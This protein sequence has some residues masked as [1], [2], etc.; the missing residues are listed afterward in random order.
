[1][2][3]IINILFWILGVA[4]IITTMAFSSIQRK[5]V[6]TQGIRVEVD[7]S[8]DQYFVTQPMVEEII[9]DIYFDF[10]SISIEEIN[11]QLLEESLD[12]HP[13]IRKAEVY[14]NLN[15]SLRVN[16]FQKQ[17]IA[18][19]RNLYSDYYIDEVGDSMSLSSNF[20]ASVPLI[21]GAIDSEKRK[22]IHHFIQKLNQDKF[23]NDFL[24]G[25]RIE[26]NG[27][28]ILHP[29]P[30]NH[31]IVFGQPERITGKLSKLKKYYQYIEAEKKDLN[32]IKSLN[33]KFED[34]VICRKHQRKG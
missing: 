10:D 9:R 34:Q 28:W 25:L 17:P 19:V 31:S 7:Y 2:A 8:Q 24:S 21:M 22:K 30:G 26:E 1:M 23:Y 6:P 5:A 27:E 3:R 4:G 29:K 33:L 12:N 18:R 14:S 32:E 15:G 20:Y 16:V 13:S 11:I